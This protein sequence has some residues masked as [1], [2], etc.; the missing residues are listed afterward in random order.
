MKR[1]LFALFLISVFPSVSQIYQSYNINLI[2]LSHPNQVDIGTDGRR[3]SGCWGWYQ[4]SKNK[5]Y[6]ISGTSNGTYFID[7]TVPTTPTVCAFLQGANGGTY[8]EIKTYQN[9]CYIASDDGQTKN[10]QIVDMQFLPDSIHVVYN[11]STL[12]RRGHTIWIDQDKLYVGAMIDDDTVRFSSMAVFSLANPAMPVLL[13]KLQQDF[14]QINYVHD[15]YVRNDTIY[16]SCAWQGLFIFKYDSVL[17]KFTQLGTYSGYPGNGFNHSSFLTNDGKHLVFCDEVPE[18]L[19]L[20]FVNVQNLGNIQPVKDWHPMP[21]TTPHNPYIKG[22]FAIVSCYQDGL[23]I[24]DISNPASINIAGYF[25]TYPQG[26]NNVGNYGSSG[27]RGNWGAYPFLPSGIIIAN[28]M[29]NGMFVLNANS[30]YT[31]TVKNPVG[32]KTET[33][34]DANLIFYPNPASNQIAVHYNSQTTST[35]QLKNILGQTVSEKAYSGSVND[36]MDV[37]SLDNGTYFISITENNI[38]KT[39]KLIVTH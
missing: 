1:T 24:Y 16:A 29:Q 31:T 22:N 11:D 18:G 4:S 9:Y 12:F 6:G 36:Y 30:A 21:L 5:E 35:L 28:D 23:H 20:H 32:L 14:P 33:I 26:G 34:S 13:R 17:N 2:S 39:K 37:R 10:F 19:P 27:Y 8:R 25:D 15:M 7:V 3:Y 38:T